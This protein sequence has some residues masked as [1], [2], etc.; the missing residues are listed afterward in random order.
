[1]SRIIRKDWE[2]IVL[3]N[4]GNLNFNSFYFE[5]M[6][7]RWYWKTNLGVMVDVTDWELFPSNRTVDEHREFLKKL[8]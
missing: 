5:M 3:D 2:K 4:G 1:M 6:N 8:N 7:Q